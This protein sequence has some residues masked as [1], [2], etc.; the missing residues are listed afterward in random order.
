MKI[1]RSIRR[2]IAGLSAGSV[3]ASGILLYSA[4]VSVGHAADF[5][6]PSYNTK[7]EMIRPD[8]SY[9]EW[10]YVGTPLTPNDLNPP[11]A[12]FP[13]FHNVYIHPDDFDHYKRTGNFPDGTVLIKELVLVGSKAAVSG[14]GYFQGDFAGLEATVKD[15]D[16]FPDDPGNWAYFSFGH[17]YPLADSAAAFPAAACNACHEAS[18]AD[19]FVFTQYYPVLRAAKGA[20][21]GRS[22][23]KDDESFE[24]MASGMAAAMEVI[25]QP[26]APTAKV[27]SAVPTDQD[28]L[29]KYLKSGGYKNFAAH[30]SGPHPTRGPHTNIGW[31]V[32]VYLDPLLDA[33]MAAGNDS[34]PVGAASV[35]EMYDDDGDLQGWAVMV[36]TEPDSAGGRGWFWYEVT[37]TR[38]GD[39]PV[40][41]GNGVPLCLGCHFPGQDFVLTNYPLQ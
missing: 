11:E 19:D 30:E 32:L 16:R 41:I 27:D 23:N 28:E 26:T 1:A 2:I 38:S 12:P 15:A 7:G 14:K 21:S 17:S 4:L 37:S 8:I 31:P 10:V 36:K 3:F 22:M 34:H 39:E 25:F 5:P 29:F 24:S 18:A 40:A 9:R 6:K 35:K 33:S 20:M 13:E